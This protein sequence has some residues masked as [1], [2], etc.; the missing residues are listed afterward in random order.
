M[1]APTFGKASLVSGECCKPGSRLYT[2]TH[3]A[4]S[5]VLRRSRAAILPAHASSVQL[6]SAPVFE[7]RCSL[8]SQ[9]TAPIPHS[10]AVLYPKSPRRGVGTPLARAEYALASHS[11]FTGLCAPLPYTDITAWFITVH[12]SPAMAAGMSVFQQ[13]ME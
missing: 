13:Q 8:S 9:S 2:A 7:S 4:R 12:K 11:A 6:W 3:D 1:Q 5:L 10:S